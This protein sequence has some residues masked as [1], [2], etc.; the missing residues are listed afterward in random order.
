MLPFDPFAASF[1]LI[2]RYEEY[3]H[4]DRDQFGRFEARSS[5]AYHHDFLRK[6]LINI[7]ANYLKELL[8]KFYPDLKFKTRRFSFVSTI[9]IDS[10]YAYKYKGLARITA[11]AIKELLNLNFSALR[12]RFDVLTGRRSD[13]FDTY[14]F[15]KNLHHDHHFDTVFFILLGDYSQHDKNLPADNDNFQNLIRSL[16]EFAEVGIHPSYRSG[17]S[18]S[19][20]T[21][22]IERL[23]R[24]LNRDITKSRQ[25]YLR[26][27][28]PD[29]YRNL[30]LADIREDYTMGYASLPGF[31]AAICDP[32]NFYDLPQET[33][34]T[35]KIYPF[36][37]MDG[38]LRDYM[39]VSSDQAIE[40]IRSLIDEV[41]A[42]EGTFI[43]LWH[44]E[45]LSDQK[46]WTGW[47]KVYE[48][49]IRYAMDH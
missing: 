32:F 9:D 44:N 3:H 15:L 43:S 41:K 16:A 27:M 35:L 18:F 6:P 29:T 10:A 7:W 34:T 5:V 26:L 31:R 46:R 4:S 28:L 20:L 2:T 39:N 19:R 37:V 21:M 8:L 36:Q 45:S 47:R 30:I 22:E 48:E 33:E 49:M 40:I 13:P 24:I 14:D 12:E 25:H 38:T 42:V 1:Y 11:A 23:S 17:E